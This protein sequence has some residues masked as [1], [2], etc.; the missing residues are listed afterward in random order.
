MVSANVPK[1]ANVLSRE[2]ANV[3]IGLL[4]YLNTS[5]KRKHLH[6]KECTEAA[7]LWQRKESK[8]YADNLPVIL[9]STEW[10]WQMPLLL[11]VSRTSVCQGKPYVLG[12][13]KKIGLQ[14]K[15]KELSRVSASKSLLRRCDNITAKK[16]NMYILSFSFSLSFQDPPN[17]L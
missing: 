8:V 10:L 7:R 11:H 12:I 4:Y 5:A 16:S 17:A 2:S 3:L 1:A 13:Q 9:R 14:I 15:N 6:N